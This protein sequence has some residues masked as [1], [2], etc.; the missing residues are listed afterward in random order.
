[1]F[2]HQNFLLQ[3]KT[4]QMLYHSYAKPEPI[5]DYHNH[6]SPKEICEDRVFEN[7]TQLWI[8]GDH[9]KYRAM[10]ALGVDEKYITGN[11]TDEEKFIAFASALPQM[12][13][14]PI[15]HWSH[16]E[17]KRYFNIDTFLNIQNAQTLYTQ[18][19]KLVKTKAYSARALLKKMHVKLVCTTDDPADNLE[20]HK[21]FKDDALRLIPGFRPDRVLNI[22]QQDYT[23]YID[24]LSKSTN[25]SISNYSDLKEALIVSI[26]HFHTT[27]CRLSDHGLSHIPPCDVDEN[28]AKEIFDLA[29]QGKE[30]NYKKA[31]TFL[32]TLLHFL[33]GEY[34]KRKWVMQLHL[35][36]IRNN[37]TRLQKQVGAD[38]G[39]DSIGDFVQAKGLSKFLNTL[40]DQ[41][42]LTKTILYNLNPADNA[43]FATMAGNFNDGSSE[44]KIQ[45]G[46]PWWF[47]DQKKGIETHLDDLSAF[48]VLSTFVGMLTD[49][50]SL[51]SFSRHE[52]FRR[53]L[54]NKLGADIEAGLLPNDIDWIGQVIKKICY[55]NTVNYFNDFK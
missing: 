9:Y 32:C 12:I 41:K 19:N 38:V 23:A 27:G 47:L 4:A 30:I 28:A 45:W 54:C 15:F 8:T 14:N 13:G 10:R 2:I 48:G 25:T 46:A 34:H 31:H 53:V 55:Q 49:S 24:T 17:L 5:V 22:M 42:K 11:A 40:D 7:I 43:L 18:L 26:D 36:P 37:N 21:A 29:L 20:F 52:Y 44:G 16:L 6:L 51:L 39:C 50:R 1:M 3:N 35:G 33:A